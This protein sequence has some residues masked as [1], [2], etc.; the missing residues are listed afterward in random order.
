MLKKVTGVILLIAGV[1]IILFMFST[2]L[3]HIGSA[4]S[5]LT[6]Q[7]ISLSGIGFFLVD[8]FISPGMLATLSVFMIWSGIRFMRKDRKTKAT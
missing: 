5:L 8:I 1:M 3:E 4:F 2:W 7:G 6:R